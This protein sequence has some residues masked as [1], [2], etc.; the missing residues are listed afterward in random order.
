MEMWCRGEIV[1]ILLVLAAAN[2]RF[3]ECGSY[4]VNKAELMTSNR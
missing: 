1:F 2:E 4:R 3:H